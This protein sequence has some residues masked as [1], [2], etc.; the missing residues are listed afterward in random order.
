MLPQHNE[1]Y[2][3]DSDIPNYFMKKTIN[4]EEIFTNTSNHCD[5]SRNLSNNSTNDVHND[6]SD[7]YNDE[8]VSIKQ[9]LDLLV[10]SQENAKNLILKYSGSPN[11]ANS[12][13]CQNTSREKCMSDFGNNENSA[14]INQFSYDKE[15]ITNDETF[16][17]LTKLEI[18]HQHPALVKNNLDCNSYLSSTKSNF[19]NS[20]FDYSSSFADTIETFIDNDLNQNEDLHITLQQQLNSMEGFINS[21]NKYTDEKNKNYNDKIDALTEES[22][23]NDVKINTISDVQNYDKSIGKIGGKRDINNIHSIKNIDSRTF[24]KSIKPFHK[25]KLKKLSLNDKPKNKMNKSSD[26]LNGGVNSKHKSSMKN[27][28]KFSINKDNNHDNNNKFTSNNNINN[29]INDIKTEKEE[30]NMDLNSKITKVEKKSI[31]K[32]VNRNNFLFHLHQIQASAATIIQKKYKKYM[33]LKLCN[34]NNMNELNKNI[35]FDNFNPN[36]SKE[37]V[38]LNENIIK[39]Q[40]FARYIIA[41]N[42]KNMLNQQKNE[43]NKKNAIIIIQSAARSYNAKKIVQKIKYEGKF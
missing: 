42:K 40:K 32:S 22:I 2:V 33:N 34:V 4:N 35:E 25:E 24:D 13:N 41:K 11:Y 21:L 3:H 16:N 37:T 26:Q 1:Q 6:K 12:E 5:E 15:L 23:K 17:K 30:K 28:N 14:V 18:L 31:S 39:I 8:N 9:A 20:N 7:L 43:N 19:E 38:I 29:N 10:K 36:N 27:N